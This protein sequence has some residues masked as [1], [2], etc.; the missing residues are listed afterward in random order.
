MN[1]TVASTINGTNKASDNP[2]ALRCEASKMAIPSRRRTTFA[3]S[4][5]A[6][7]GRKW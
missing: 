4:A 2:S 6:S 7:A 1:G 5:L 3:S